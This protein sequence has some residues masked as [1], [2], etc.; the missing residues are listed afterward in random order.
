MHVLLLEDNPV[1]RLYLTRVLLRL[2]DIAFEVTAC[3]DLQSA[4]VYRD[5]R[6]FDVALI[7]LSLPDSEGLATYESI[8]AAFPGL[9]VVVLT[10]TH[11]DTL[12]LAAIRSGAQ[13]Y[14][15]KGSHI[16][17]PIIARVLRHAVERYK[18]HQQL[19]EQDQRYRHMLSHVPAIVWTMD[20]SFHITSAAGATL[21]AMNVNAAQLVGKSLHDV[22]ESEDAQNQSVALAAHEQAMQGNEIGY[23]SEW[24]DHLFQVRVVPLNGSPQKQ[25]GVLGVAL[26]ITEQRRQQHELEFARVI[27]ESLL[28]T[29]QPQ[30]DGFDIYGASHPAMQTCGDWYDYLWW[31]NGSLGLVVGD[32][33]G[34]GYGPAIMSAALASYLESAVESQVEPHEMVS[35]CNR[36][37]SKHSHNNGFAVLSLVRLQPSEKTFEYMG[38]GEGLLV[39]DAAGNLRYDVPANG[40]PLGIYPQSE[41]DPL[42]RFKLEAGDILLVLTDGFREAHADDA[43]RLFG[44]E[45]ILSVVREHRE[46]TAEEIFAALRQACHEFSLPNHVHD[47]MTGII[48]KVLA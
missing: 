14:L 2:Q 17:G 6:T 31:A 32:V 36:L 44:R 11:D 26:D 39:L 19:D 20:E 27:Q 43:T 15:V 1:D 8:A 23:E 28:P 45:R 16:S 4:L 40:L 29:E 13:D 5:Q 9:P 3:N 35:L 10:G 41:Y 33:S 46:K 37:Y 12:A 47:D 7:D 34:K 30:F 48:V 38:A 18:Y 21:R 42:Q 24:L 25:A 22:L